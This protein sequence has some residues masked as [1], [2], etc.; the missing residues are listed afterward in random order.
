MNRLKISTAF[1][2]VM[3][4]TTVL[5]APCAPYTVQDC[6][7]YNSWPMMQAIGQRLVCTSV[8]AP[9]ITSVKA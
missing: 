6:E 9:D 8:A 5:A 3:M 2:A 1:A 4:A 7:G